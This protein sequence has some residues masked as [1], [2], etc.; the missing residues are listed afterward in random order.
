MG[1]RKGQE[2]WCASVHRVAKTWT[3]LKRL[4]NKDKN[5]NGTGKN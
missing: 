2:A 1:D 5:D 3:P 4:N